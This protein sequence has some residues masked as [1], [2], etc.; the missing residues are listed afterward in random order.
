[1]IAVCFVQ[2]REGGFDLVVAREDAEATLARLRRFLLRSK[3]ALEL[4]D[5]SGGPFA[6]VAD[7]IDAS[8]PGANELAKALTPHTFG[9]RFVDETIS[10][11]KG[12]FTG[13]E[14]VGRLRRPGAGVCRGASYA[15]RVPVRTPSMTI[16]AR[17]NRWSSRDYQRYGARRASHRTGCGASHTARRRV[18]KRRHCARSE[19]TPRRDNLTAWRR[20]VRFTAEGLF[21]RSGITSEEDALFS[22]GL[23]ANAIGFDFAGRP[24]DPRGNGARHRGSPPERRRDGS[25][26]RNELPQRVCEIADTL[27]LTAVQIDGAI[28]G[29]EL[30]YITAR[31]NTVCARSPRALKNLSCGAAWTI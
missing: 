23:G 31:V 28:S 10:F 15:S 27:G 18:S 30:S 7:Q 22:V 26:F 25:S 1:M 4:R 12:C 3:C 6:T 21:I 29:D 17:R 2:P 13:Q 9:R 11:T 24:P 19:L 16:S 14:L 5:A 8:W 20:H